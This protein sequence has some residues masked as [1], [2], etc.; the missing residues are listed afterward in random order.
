[1]YYP[2]NDLL[3]EIYH[4]I[5]KSNI[6]LLN[7]SSKR[8]KIIN[9]RIKRYVYHKKYDN[10]NGGL[11]VGCRTSDIGLVKLMI[12]RGANDWNV[13]LYEACLG[14]GISIKLI[15]KINNWPFLMALPNCPSDLGHMKIVRLMIK[16]GANDWDSGL[17][18]A[19][20]SCNMKIVKL[21]IRRGADDWDWGLANA[22]RFGNMRIVKL[23][24]E[25]GATKCKYCFKS[26][27]EHLLKK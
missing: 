25:K 4:Y 1:M 3:F 24:I 12:K 26:I 19:C 2:Y 15:A 23:M 9:E 27:Q 10:M 5:P 13:G 8:M 21:M 6:P 11:Y 17:Y 22:C 14:K 20:F 18:G 7:K 16:K